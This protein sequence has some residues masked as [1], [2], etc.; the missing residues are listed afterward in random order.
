MNTT[1]W[2]GLIGFFALAGALAERY[3][4]AGICYALLSGVI[5][6]TAVLILRR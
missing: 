2:I 5:F 4:L 1:D 3:G 6:A